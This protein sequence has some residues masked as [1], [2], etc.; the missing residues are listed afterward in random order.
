[1]EKQQDM[2]AW[3]SGRELWTMIGKEWMANVSQQQ[4]AVFVAGI[5]QFLLP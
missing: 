3:Q 1:M 4:D 5:H 2:D